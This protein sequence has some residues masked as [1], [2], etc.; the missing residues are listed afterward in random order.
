MPWVHVPQKI[1]HP[2]YRAIARFRQDTPIHGFRQTATMGHSSCPVT[3][4]EIFSRVGCPAASSSLGCRRKSNCTI[5]VFNAH[6]VQRRDPFVPGELV[7]A[8]KPLRLLTLNHFC[9]FTQR[10]FETVWGIVRF[11]VLANFLFTELGIVILKLEHSEALF[12]ICLLLRL[13]QRCFPRRL[14]FGWN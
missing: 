6:P 10:E 2:R 5:S 7:T 9:L 8:E 12:A 14:E 11:K 13:S 3:Q 1:T 4:S